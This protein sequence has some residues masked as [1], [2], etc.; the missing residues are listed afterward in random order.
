MFRGVIFG[1]LSNSIFECVDR[2]GFTDEETHAFFS[3]GQCR[4]SEDTRKVD[5]EDVGF[6]DCLPSRLVYDA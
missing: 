1:C 6:H 5:D 4:H 3:C 2:T